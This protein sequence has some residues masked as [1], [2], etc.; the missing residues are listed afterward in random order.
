MDSSQS[1]VFELL[2]NYKDDKFK[3]I[4]GLIKKYKFEEMFANL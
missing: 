4:L 1:V 2:Q 3:P